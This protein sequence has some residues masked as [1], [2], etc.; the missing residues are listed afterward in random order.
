VVDAIVNLCRERVERVDVDVDDGTY[1]DNEVRECVFG[2]RR[3][4]HANG[5]GV[6]VD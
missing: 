2:H 3:R 1:G 5:I 4:R 6:K